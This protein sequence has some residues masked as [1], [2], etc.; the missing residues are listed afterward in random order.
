MKDELVFIYK[1]VNF[2][3][4][5]KKTVVI[6]IHGTVCILNWNRAK[7]VLGKETMQSIW[8]DSRSTSDTKQPYFLRLHCL[9]KSCYICRNAKNLTNVT[10]L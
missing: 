2:L 9:P 10:V 8:L 7:P 5:F 3:A 1:D 4:R 6:A